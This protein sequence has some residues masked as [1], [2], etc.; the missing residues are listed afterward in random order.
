MNISQELKGIVGFAFL[1]GL[2]SAYLTRQAIFAPEAFVESAIIIKVFFSS[3]N[4]ILLAGLVFNYTQIYR[5]MPTS[6][7]RIFLVFSSA[8]MF[9]AIS[10]NPL[11]HLL[12]GYEFIP[13]G[14][15]TYVPDMFVTAASLSVLYESY[16]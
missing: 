9:Y 10:S 11:V 7:S 14:P 15:F 6:T 4:A 1:I 13:L 12:F 2:V 5:D 16:K 3:I 8:L